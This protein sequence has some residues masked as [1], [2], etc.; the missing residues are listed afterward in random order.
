MV[1]ATKLIFS[2]HQTKGNKI[3]NSMVMIGCE[4]LLQ[5]LCDRISLLCDRISLWYSEV[6]SPET[7]IFFGLN[8]RIVRALKPRMYFIRLCAIAMHLDCFALRPGI[9]R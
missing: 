2:S 1:I 5:T 7:L 8:W 9:F 3:S 4:S 6:I